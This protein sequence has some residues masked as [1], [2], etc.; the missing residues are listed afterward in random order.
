M[1]LLSALQFGLSGFA[2][3]IV[4]D[5]LATTQGARAGLTFRGTIRVA[6]SIRCSKHGGAR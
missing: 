2:A 6:P 4:R 5:L 3:S 1:T